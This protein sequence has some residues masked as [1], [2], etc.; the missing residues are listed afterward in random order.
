MKISAEA[1]T[2]PELM[3][4]VVM[5]THNVAP[6][7]AEAIETVLGQEVGGMEL[8]VVDDH[9]DD[10]T[11][12]IVTSYAERDH[13]VALVE[14]AGRGGGSARNQGVEHARGKYLI[15]CDGDDIVPDGAYAALV[16]S[17]EHS[18]SVLAMGDYLKFRAVDTWRPTE[19]MAAYAQPQSGI[20][21]AEEPTIVYSRPCWNK[22]FLRSWWESEQ[23][24]Y[25]DVPRSNDIVPMMTAYLSAR[26]I[27]IVPDVVYLYRERPGMG[28]MTAQSDSVASMLSYLEQERQCALLVA[29][30]HNPE[31]DRVF[32]ALVYDR[33][34][35]M[36]VYKYLSGWAGPGEGDTR[37]R[38]ALQRLLDVTPPPSF[39]LDPVKRAVLLL[40][41]HG[42]FKAA[43]TLAFSGEAFEPSVVSDPK[44]S[45]ARLKEWKRLLK[46]LHKHDAF[47]HGLPE[48]LAVALT[49]VL[50]EPVAPA[51][52]GVWR[53]LVERIEA[54]LGPSALYFV[55]E[56]HRPKQTDT[57]TLFARDRAA[58][59]LLQ[60]VQR[61]QSLIAVGMATSGERRFAPVMAGAS[62][63]EGAA[64]VEAESVVWGSGEEAEEGRP[65]DRWEAVFPLSALPLGK[66]FVI[67][68][69]LAAHKAVVSMRHEAPMPAYRAKDDVLYEVMSGALTIRRRHH[70]VLRATRR[71]ARIGR[72]RVRALLR[73]VA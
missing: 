1:I 61:G 40:A 65:R 16:N 43:R 55:P 2:A 52:V 10:R 51:A 48:R 32:S 33:D 59:T 5:P 68:A 42:E 29:E 27:D 35:F 53:K 13:R 23:I 30:A 60:V 6:W 31:I 46:A 38:D 37:V 20:I 17:L 14:A 11:R 4:S 57:V 50:A 34:T 24:R 56:A 58:C 64:I 7:V 49:R 62:G 19:S 71:G 41:S 18:G 47:G 69:Q 63:P 54:T 3:L 25:P 66:P 21:L 73:K 67:A 44:R 8:I 45:R 22:A 12:E 36:Q 72:D 39:P 26:A 28:S 15:F 9:S 70:W